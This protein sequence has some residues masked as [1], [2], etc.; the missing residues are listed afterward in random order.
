MLFVLPFGG[1]EKFS[2]RQPKT[3]TINLMAAVRVLLGIFLRHSAIASTKALP[4][5]TTAR[6]VAPSVGV[7]LARVIARRNV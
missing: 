2:R 5:S 3:L 4:L 1:P 7:L 6:K